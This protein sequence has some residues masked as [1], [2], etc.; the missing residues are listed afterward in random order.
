MTDPVGEIFRPLASRPEL[1]LCFCVVGSTVFKIWRGRRIGLSLMLCY[2][3][4]AN[5]LFS[6]SLGAQWDI[7]LAD[8]L[9]LAA[10]SSICRPDAGATDQGRPSAPA[11]HQADCTLCCGACPMGGCTSLAVGSCP[12]F[13]LPSVQARVPSLVTALASPLGGRRLY[14]SDSLSQAPPA[15]A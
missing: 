6:A 15:L 13:S 14:P 7:A 5:A 12:G 1:W 9:R 8:P 2:V 11:H 10:L 4:L 3:L